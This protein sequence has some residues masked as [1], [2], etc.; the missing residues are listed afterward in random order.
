MAGFLNL[1]ASNKIFYQNLDV[2]KKTGFALLVL[3][4]LAV[5]V[6]AQKAYIQ[7]GANLANITKDADGNTDDRKGLYTFNVGIL[8]SLGLSKTVDIETGLLFT[9]KGAKSESNFG[10]GDYIKSTFNPLYVEVPVNVLLRF[11]LVGKT[12][13]LF[14]HAGPYVAMGVAGKSKYESKIGVLSSNS[15]SNI[16]FNNDNPT[17][18]Q[19]EDASYAKIKRFDYGLNFGG[20]IALKSLIL[21]ANYG[22]GLAKINSTET[23]NSADQ[24]NKYRTLSL[25][26]GIPL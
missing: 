12:N 14:V 6:N 11:P 21:K 4:G 22:L 19:Q 10:N 18:A 1:G 24:K 2:M 8:G 5:S 25:S 17:T 15:E 9:G 16:Q 13:N 26:V 3:T 20:G 23:N 7:G